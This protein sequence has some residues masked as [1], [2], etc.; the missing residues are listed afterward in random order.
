MVVSIKIFTKAFHLFRDIKLFKNALYSG[1]SF[2]LISLTNFL[3]LPFFIA[4]LGV[5]QFGI[6][7]LV[8]SL[9]GYYGILDLGIGQ[10][11]VKFISERTANK[12]KLHEINSGINS[13]FSVMLLISLIS[14]VL[15]F[16]FSAAISEFLNVG[17]QNIAATSALIKIVSLGFFFSMLSSVF[18]SVLMGLQLYNLTSKVDAFNNI[19][20]NVVSLAIL[21]LFTGS[22]L[23]ELVALNAFISFVTFVI[24]LVLVNKQF[25]GLQ[26]KLHININFLKQFFKFSI[27]IFLSKL[28]N[29]YANYIVKFIIGIF[30]GPAAVTYFT[31][32]SKLIGAFG[33]ILSS[34][35]GTLMPYISVLK[36]KEQDEMIKEMTI[37]ISFIFSTISIPVSLFI[38]IFSKPILEVW[39]G[40]AF[41]NESWVI[42]S[43]MCASSTIASFSTIP[44]LVILGTGSSKLLGY[45]SV[46]TV[47]LYS[48]LLPL[49]TKFYLLVGAAAALLITSLVLV[50]IVIQKTTSYLNISMKTYL[51]NVF[52][53]HTIPL[54]VFVILG[55]FVVNLDVIL[56]PIKLSIGIMLTLLYYLYLVLTRK[57]SFTVF[58]TAA[59]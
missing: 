57:N 19:T 24:Y 1:G 50:S 12:E 56:F 49:L 40:P 41:A 8:I 10:G 39:M 37:L 22:G 11:L 32:P 38:T 42:L 20:I 46:L 21:Y 33:G 25:A 14:S 31:V 15:L 52:L 58:A 54:S 34:A 13:A 23:K 29:L 6:Y 16:V 27:H 36:S 7:I 5:E 45:F 53:F 2:F 59:K 17:Q 51:T 26:I 48:I 44:N 4:N 47:I 18:S 55:C 3:T 43:I 30:A 35:A 9:F 28:S